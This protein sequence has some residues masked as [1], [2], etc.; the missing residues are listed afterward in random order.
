M[1]PENAEYLKGKKTWYMAAWPNNQI[2]EAAKPAE[3]LKGM[4]NRKVWADGK[5]SRWDDVFGFIGCSEQRNTAYRPLEFCFGVD[6]K[7]LNLWGC[8]NARMDW[9]KWAD[10]FSYGSFKKGGILKGGHVFE[11]D[12]KRIR[13]ELETNLY[14][15]RFCPHFSFK[16]IEAVVTQFPD[17]VV[18]KPKGDWAYKEDYDE[19]PGAIQVKEKVVE[20]GYTYTNEFYSSGVEP[21][22]PALGLQILKRAFDATGIESSGLQGVLSYRGE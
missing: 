4:R 13:H 15:F 22:T 14:R 6:E 3:D 19:S 5:E 17:Q 16:L 1:A 8:K 11:F 7:R 21:Y 20:D 2:A 18:I 10:W 9:V 12:K